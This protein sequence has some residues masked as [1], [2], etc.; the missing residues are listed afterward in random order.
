MIIALE[1]LH[2]AVFGIG[3][4]MFIIGLMVEFLR[5][6]EKNDDKK[7]LTESDLWKMYKK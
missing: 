5:R 6:S 7:P 1:V 2:W 4:I 3:C